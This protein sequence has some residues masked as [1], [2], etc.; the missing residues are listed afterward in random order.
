MN[1][2]FRNVALLLIVLF[3][4]GG[5]ASA[6]SN[7]R[8]P[9]IPALYAGNG[10]PL[11]QPW[12]VRAEFEGPNTADFFN[13]INNPASPNASLLANPQ[14]AVGPEDILLVANSQIWRLPNGNA[15][16]VIPTGLYPGNQLIGGQAFGAQRVSLDNWIGATALAQLCPTGNTDASSGRHVRV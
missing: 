9:Q 15:P 4:A 11:I 8:S 16:G 13:T 14:I 5:L 1:C 10:N 3:C 2:R 7:S 12:N 6:Q